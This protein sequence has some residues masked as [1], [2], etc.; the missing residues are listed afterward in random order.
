MKTDLYLNNFGFLI[1]ADIEKETLYIGI[2]HLFEGAHILL[3]LPQIG[4]AVDLACFEVD[5][6]GGGR[7]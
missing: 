2:A 3:Y 4:F 1:G 6:P 7:G 5:H